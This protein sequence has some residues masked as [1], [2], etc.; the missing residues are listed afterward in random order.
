MVWKLAKPALPISA[1]MALISSSCISGDSD[2]CTRMPSGFS[3]RWQLAK[4]AAL[5]RPSAGP[6]G[7]VEST[8]TTSTLPGSQ[9][10]M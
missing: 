4:N 5:N 9:L 6:T 10:A 8:I 1:R 7:S 3:A 2:C